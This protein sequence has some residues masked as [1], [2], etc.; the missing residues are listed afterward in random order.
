MNKKLCVVTIAFMAVAGLSHA[1]T[2]LGKNYVGGSFGIFQFGDDEL[3]DGLGNAYTVGGEGNINLNPNIDLNLSVAY[4]W[5][6]GDVAGVDID[7]TAIS[8]G[9]GLTYF[10]KPNEK[11]NPYVRAAVVVVN[12]ES[13]FSGG[14]LSDEDSTEVGVRAGAGVEFEASEKILLRG[15]LDYFTIDSKDDFILGAGVGY[16]FN[17]QVLGQIGG[18]YALDS[19]DAIATIGLVF[20]L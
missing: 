3:D 15:G 18:T 17:E 2:L 13:E 4:L 6:D 20:K 12:A 9:A 5:A 14:G 10:F 7:V 8:V 1:E 16:W 19:E 11:V